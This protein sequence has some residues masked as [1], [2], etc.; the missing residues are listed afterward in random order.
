MKKH[1]IWILK[2]LSSQLKG[3]NSQRQIKKAGRK[4]S[5]FLHIPFSYLLEDIGLKIKR[6][7]SIERDMLFKL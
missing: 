4:P 1:N 3:A 6:K 5:S 7:E 2:R